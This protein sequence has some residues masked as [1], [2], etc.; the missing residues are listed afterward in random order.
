M[1]CLGAVITQTRAECVASVLSDQL[2]NDLDDLFN[3]SSREG[4]SMKLQAAG[5]SC[6]D[7]LCREGLLPCPLLTGHFLVFH[8]HGVVPSGMD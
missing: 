5:K 8:H 4:C 1:V 6:S 2:V 7:A 3:L